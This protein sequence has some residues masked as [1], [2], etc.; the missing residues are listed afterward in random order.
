M[1][2]KKK[3]KIYI[4]AGEVSGDVL[5]AK[6][7]REMPDSD[8]SGVGGGNM[9]AQGLNSLFPISDLAVMGLFEVLAHAR[10]LTARIAQTA[11][12]IAESKPDIVLTIDSPGFAKRVIKRVKSKIG[13][14][15]SEIRFYH[16]VA[17]QVWAWGAGRA[18][19]FS[20][21][22]DKLYSF[23]EFERPYFTKYGLDTVAV[24]HPIADGLAAVGNPPSPRLR[25]ASRNEEPTFA[26]ATVGRQE[27]GIKNRK[28]ITLLPGSRMSEVKKLMPVFHSVVNRMMADGTFEFVIPTTET[29]DAF[30]RDKIRGWA[31]KPRLIPFNE[32]YRILKASYIAIAA[33]GTI[34]AELAIMHIPAVVV[35]KMNPLTMW[36]ARRVVKIK[37]VSLVNI[38]LGK[39]VYPELLGRGATAENIVREVKRLSETPAREKM[40]AS[41]AS[42]DRMWRCRAGKTASQLIA[43]DVRNNNQ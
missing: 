24:G 39:T 32:R 23:F 20:K 34:S 27:R 35:Y 8:F 38:L 16:V 5:G 26:K 42:A 15:K 13:N 31:V 40:I 1:S 9:Q 30:I 18:K 29:T 10:T 17:P 4:I 12:A 33:S 6:I 37:W 2:N 22:F 7:M 41:L 28:I 21:I 43:Q 19:K 14:Q 25:W 11:A 3:L 36:L